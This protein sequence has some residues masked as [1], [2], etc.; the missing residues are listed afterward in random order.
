MSD[1]R[2]NALKR[3]I[4]HMGYPFDHT[5]PMAKRKAW[6]T[7]IVED[8]EKKYPVPESYIPTKHGHFCNQADSM[9]NGCSDSWWTG[10]NYGGSL[11]RNPNH[12][13]AKAPPLD[14]NCPYG[15]PYAQAHGGQKQYRCRRD[16]GEDNE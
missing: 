7:E 5:W 4:E 10:G 13:D 9:G 8:I 15:G 14:Y 1:V 11:C 2:W 3:R 12:H 16:G 6:L